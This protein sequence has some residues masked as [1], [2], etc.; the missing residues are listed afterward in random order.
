ME[1]REGD[2]WQM[3][4][5]AQST[6]DLLETLV[7]S[8]FSGIYLDRYGY[9][10]EGRTI[11]AELGRLLGGDPVV[12]KNQRLVFYKITQYDGSR[13]QGSGATQ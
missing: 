12:S 11:E 6:E 9:A 5:T 13:R 7:R 10:D 3:E 8:G 1:G 2:R 4:V